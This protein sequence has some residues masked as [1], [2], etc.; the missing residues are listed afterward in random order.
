VLNEFFEN[1]CS[2]SCLALFIL[3][4]SR[5]LLRVNLFSPAIAT[6]L[7]L[8]VMGL[9]IF[10]LGI[11]HGLMPLGEQVGTCLKRR[12]PKLLVLATTFCLGVLCSIAEP[13]IGT[14]EAAGEDTIETRTPLLKHILDKPFVLMLGVGAGVGFA[15]IFGCARL[16][17]DLPIKRCIFAALLPTLSLTLFCVSQGGT[18]PEITGLAWDC[19]AVTTGPLTVPIVLSLG[20]GIA[21]N[22]RRGSVTSADEPSLSGFGIVTF[23][24]LF[25]VFSVWAIGWAFGGRSVTVDPFREADSSGDPF[26]LPGGTPKEETA[27]PKVDVVAACLGA[28]RAVLPLASFLLLVLLL[29]RE[30]LENW[31]VVVAGLLCCVVGMSLFT[32]GL[33]RGLVPLGALAGE[34]L[35]NAVVFYGRAMGS[36]LIFA[37]G[38]LSGLLATFSE[39]ALA[40]FGKTVE[41]LSHGSYS[42][43]TWRWILAFR[44]FEPVSQNRESPKP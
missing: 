43:E 42:K 28:C 14:L 11:R 30:K 22:A 39:P 4:Y 7:F 32:L 29:L 35:P 6:N 40:A 41:Q 5:L 20:V 2:V 36:L 26:F 12:V 10:G 27:K 13:A 24:S 44:D 18:F 16:L 38:F 8:A 3:I 31:L 37:F 15:C 9:T 17:Y 34:N 33:E 19:G 23:A 21:A 1:C 25:P